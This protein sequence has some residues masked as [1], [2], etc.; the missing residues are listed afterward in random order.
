MLKNILYVVFGGIFCTQVEAF[1]CY[2]TLAK[3]SCWVDYA[4]SM[5][6]KDTATGTVLTTVA[7]AYNQTWGRQ[8]FTCQPGQTLSFAA[9]YSPSIWQG[10][11]DKWYFGENYISLPTKIASNSIAWNIPICYATDFAGVSIPPSATG[12]CA[13]DF[14]NIPTINATAS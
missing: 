10:D 5:N 12:H 8:S 11:R 6:V 14:K 3:D 4:V 9:Q 2:V 13:C 1:T 7:I